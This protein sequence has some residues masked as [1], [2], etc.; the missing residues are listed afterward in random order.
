MCEY[1]L[2]ISG[3]TQALL[4]VLLKKTLDQ[5]LRRFRNLNPVLYWIW[6]V[7]LALFY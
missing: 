2:D 7:Y 3:L 1:L 4:P 5:I 6:E